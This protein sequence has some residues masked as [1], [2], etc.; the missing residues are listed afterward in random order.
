M[1]ATPMLMGQWPAAALMYRCGYIQQG[2]PVV[3]EQ[4]S[5][6]DLCPPVSQERL[7]TLSGP[8]GPRHRASE[9]TTFGIEERGAIGILR[10]D[11]S[12]EEL[13]LR[14]ADGWQ[15]VDYSSLGIHDKSART[16]S[17]RDLTRPRRLVH[18]QLHSPSGWTGDGTAYE[19][20]KAMEEIALTAGYVLERADG[21]LVCYNCRIRLT[22]KT[23]EVIP[24][25]AIVRRIHVNL[26]T[27]REVRVDFAAGPVSDG[28]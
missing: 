11:G 1:C 22:G 21:G 19:I 18:D 12:M 6:A 15:K 9:T 17:R 20:V 25:E 24:A 5:L 28:P 3:Y 14:Y 23:L 2:E 27:P 13:R 8:H 10:Q 4:R 7:Y 26:K 16:G